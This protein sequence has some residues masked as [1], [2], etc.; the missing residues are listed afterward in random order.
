MELVDLQLE[1]GN[2]TWI[3]GGEDYTL[4][5]KLKAIK[6]EIERRELKSPWKP[7]DGEIIYSEWMLFNNGV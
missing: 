4:A 6:R 7:G 2:Y 1:G 3:I 5:G